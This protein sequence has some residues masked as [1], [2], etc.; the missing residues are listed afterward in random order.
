MTYPEKSMPSQAITVFRRPPE[1]LNC[2][3]AVLH[4]AR[5]AEHTVCELEELSSAGGGRAPEG[6]CGAL[7]AALSLASDEQ[8]RV[9]MK[10]AFEE[11][12]GATTC[13]VIRKGKL[14]SCEH[15]VAT[16]AELLEAH[17]SAHSASA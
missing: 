5:E 1:R 6:T 16:A 13:H 14:L 12:A 15:C 17:L 9:F 2:A 4:A 11:I 8:G 7:Y 3:Q 10:Q